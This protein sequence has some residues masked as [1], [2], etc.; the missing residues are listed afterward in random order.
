MNQKRVAS[1]LLLLP[2][3]YL[4]SQNIHTT[5]SIRHL[6]NIVYRIEIPYVEPG[7]K[8]AESIW[9]LPKIP[10]NGLEYLQLINSSVDTL[11][12]YEKGKKLDYYTYKYIVYEQAD[13]GSHNYN[14]YSQMR[15]YLK[16]PYQYRDSVYGYS[17]GND[18]NGN[19]GYPVHGF[20]YSVVEGIGGL[21]DGETTI[22]DVALIH[23]CSDITYKYSDGTTERHKEDRYMWYCS[24]CAYA[25]MESVNT[26]RYEK[27]DLVP[28]TRVSNLYLPYVQLDPLV[29]T[30]RSQLL[31]ELAIADAAREALSLKQGVGAI[32]AIDATLS[33]DGRIVTVNYQLS[34]DSDISI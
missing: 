7:A 30:A 31:A 6:G 19:G 3:H 8:G 16:T 15:P 4:F 12:I 20:G 25:F 33:S 27:D 2:I 18:R 24:G 29:T 26:A 10:D 5:S 9:S 13:K 21:T 28:I 11:I 14:I 17:I 23:H 34:S 32:S 22:K 1:I